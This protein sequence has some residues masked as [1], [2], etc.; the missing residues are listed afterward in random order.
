M[1]YRAIFEVP[2]TAIIEITVDEENQTDA[3]AAAYDQVRRATAAQARISGIAADGATNVALERTET[4]AGQPAVHVP[5]AQ[6][7]AASRQDGYEL[8]LY[9]G[10]PSDPDAVA[11]RT[12]SF[13]GFVGASQAFTELVLSPGG[14]YGGGVVTNQLTGRTEIS[15]RNPRGGWEVKAFQ[16]AQADEPANFETWLDRKEAMQAAKSYAARPDINRVVI[17]DYT[18]REVGSKI[19][20][21]IE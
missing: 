18:D 13:P 12:L 14:Q 6:T 21:T 19:F 2:A 4:P 10:L 5:S 16:S 17:Y 7:V 8:H 1:K 3:L 20:R 11:V 15:G 9:K